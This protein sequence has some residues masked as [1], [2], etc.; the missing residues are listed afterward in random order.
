[1]SK[2]LFAAVFSFFVSAKS[3]AQTFNVSGKVM[4]ES[5]NELL[6]FAT[7]TYSATGGAVTDLEGKFSLTLQPGTYF[8]TASYV[9]YEKLEKKIVLK[10]SDLVVDFSLKLLT[11]NEIK[12]TADVVTTRQSPIAFSEMSSKQIKEVASSQDIPMLLNSTPG[13]YATQSGGGYG[14]ARITIRGFDQR[15][16]GVLIDGVP[17]NDMENGQVYWSNWNG[18]GDVTQT[19]QVQRG[20]GA[21]KLAITSVGGTMNL[22]TEGIFS[23]QQINFRQEIG[24]NG[25]EK[26][27]IAITTGKMKKGWGLTLAGNH[28]TG[29]GWVNQTWMESWS[30]FLK[31]EKQLK[32]HT[33]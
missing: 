12:I 9:G 32:H 26:T 17:V 11:L 4:D 20:L 13:V 30:Y 2:F 5:S 22:I 31:L 8:I 18:L 6:P 33:I 27:G 16:I 14:D 1:M 7:V 29:N 28:V 10:N 25:Y 21:S 24:S 23:K 19:M 3:E 15:N